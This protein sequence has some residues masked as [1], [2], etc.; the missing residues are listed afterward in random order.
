MTPEKK[1]H[2]AVASEGEKIIHNITNF[3]K[4]VGR[5]VIWQHIS[6]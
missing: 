4:S 6:G 5:N 3:K 1:S 2:G